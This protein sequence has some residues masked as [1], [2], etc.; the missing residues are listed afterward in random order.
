MAM[1][2]IVIGFAIVF[3]NINEKFQEDSA[4]AQRSV[5]F[6]RR[7]EAVKAVGLTTSGEKMV[8]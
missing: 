5:T 4:V 6:Q 3:A 7:A 8:Y 1:I 2:T